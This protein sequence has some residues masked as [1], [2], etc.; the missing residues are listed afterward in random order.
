[1][2]PEL[3]RLIEKNLEVSKESNEMLRKMRSTMRWSRFFR[4]IYWVIII[5]SMLGVYYMLEPRIKSL[6]ASY[7]QVMGGIEKAQDTL[8]AIPD[9]ILKK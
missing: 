3:K 9:S 4:F 7:E 2:D 5:G 6:I 1:M 8:N